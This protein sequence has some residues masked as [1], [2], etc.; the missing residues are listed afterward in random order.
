MNRKL[1]MFGLLYCGIAAGALLTNTA[2]VVRRHSAPPP[3]GQTV[4]AGGVAT[5]GGGTYTTSVQV[6]G[7][8]VLASGVV[9]IESACSPGA[10][11]RCDGLDNNCNGAIDEGCGYQTGNVQITLAWNTGADIDMY[12]TNP[13]GETI[14]YSTPNDSTGGMLDHDARGACGGSGN[15]T[16]EN[17]YWG[18]NP[19]RGNY[20]VELHYWAGNSCSYNAGPTMTTL[21]IS[22]GGQVIG[23]YNYQLRPD[24]RVPIAQFSL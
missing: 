23:A 18:G 24:Q 21:S 16:V 19:P 2:C 13:N 6:S 15:A 7:Q 12:V 20:Q 1:V 8:P 11:E 10:Q 14:N 22:V 3:Q 9:V 17:V 5:S 4:M